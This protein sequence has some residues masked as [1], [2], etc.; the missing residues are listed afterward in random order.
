MAPKPLKFAQVTFGSS[1]EQSLSVQVI[2]TKMLVIS[3]W[4]FT[5]S[6]GDNRI[7]VIVESRIAILRF[8]FKS[9]MLVE[10]S[11]RSETSS[12]HYKSVF[13]VYKSPV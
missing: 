5:N 1:V 8:E 7:D 10:L 2:L 13:I 12:Y 6:S 3:V 4:N 9:R 11:S